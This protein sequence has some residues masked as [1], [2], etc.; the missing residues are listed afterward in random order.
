[1][2]EQRPWT[3]KETSCLG[4]Q[5]DREIATSLGRTEESVR[6]KRTALAIPPAA[7]RLKRWT[8][9]EDGLLGSAPDDQ[10]AKQLGRT[11][12]AVTARRC[13]LGIV[14]ANAK[15]PV[16]S[17]EEHL[18]AA[19]PDPDALKQLKSIE[20][21]REGLSQEDEERFKLL[22]GPYYP[23]R[24]ARGKFMVCEW[25]GAVRVGGYSD[26]PIPWPY[27]FRT[28]LDRASRNALAKPWTPEEIEL[29]G[30]KPDRVLARKFK[31]SA[32]SVQQKRKSLGI[33]SCTGRRFWRAADDN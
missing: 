3:E 8:A 20:V 19:A 30:T 13:A 33:P 6:A 31:R 23:P 32:R 21:P 11:R 27:A 5:S 12:V 18:P 9:N 7:L 2:S 22:H 4:T 15:G 1:M 16:L 10:V 24:T 28:G 14:S 26:A 25:R 29:L 17:P